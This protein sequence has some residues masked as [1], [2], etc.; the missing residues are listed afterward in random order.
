MDRSATISGDPGS[1][2]MSGRLLTWS[3]GPVV[4][5]LRWL[6]VLSL[7]AVFVAVAW[8]WLV[9]STFAADSQRQHLV[10]RAVLAITVW[11][12]YVL[13]RLLDS[14]RMSFHLPA[15]ARHRFAH[16]WAGVLWPLW[17]TALLWNT[18]LVC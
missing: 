3:V 17:A 15:A 8:H 1:L 10:Q 9:A 12:I 4:T 14:R 2:T 6:N 13:D 5:L 18:W 16:R 7:D 11:L